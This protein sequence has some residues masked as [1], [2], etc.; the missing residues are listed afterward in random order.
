MFTDRALTGDFR[1]DLVTMLP[2]LRSYA[3]SLTRDRD[4]ANDLVQQTVLKSLAGLKSFLPGTNFP[5]WL[6]RIEHNEFIS[7][8]RR[9]DR[10]VELDATVANSLWYPPHQESGIDMRDFKTAFR[11][12]ASCQRKALLLTVLEGRSH[13]SIAALSG[14]SVGTVKSRVSRART[15]LRQILGNDGGTFALPSRERPGSHATAVV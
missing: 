1:T 5:A 8:L 3:M 7:S 6:F 13:K 9:Q 14:V 10:T 4:R 15:K 11:T 12:L 2:R